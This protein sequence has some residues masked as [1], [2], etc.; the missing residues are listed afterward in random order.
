MKSFLIASLMSVC[1]VLSGHAADAS[2]V[3]AGSASYWDGEDV[4]SGVVRAVRLS[5]LKTAPATLLVT[6]KRDDEIE[7]SVKGNVA[8]YSDAVGSRL[9][10]NDLA[11]GMPVLVKYEKTPEGLLLATAVKVLSTAP[12]QKERP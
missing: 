6:D 5:S 12:A 4:L 8:V 10:F 7:F 11:Q 1:V 2:A 9:G 3:N